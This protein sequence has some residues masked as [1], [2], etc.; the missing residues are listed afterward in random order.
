MKDAIQDGC[1]RGRGHFGED[2]GDKLINIIKL[3]GCPQAKYGHSNFFGNC[4]HVIFLTSEQTLRKALKIILCDCKHNMFEL[5]YVAVF[6]H[7][8][9]GGRL[10]KKSLLYFLY[11]FINFH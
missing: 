7:G 11:A 5:W 4:I 9:I 8:Q 2:I 6:T 10:D 3:Q 1:F